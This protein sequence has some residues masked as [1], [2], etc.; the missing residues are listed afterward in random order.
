MKKAIKWSILIIGALFGAVAW[1][2]NEKRTIIN[3]FI[4]FKRLCT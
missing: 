3:P 4:N 2:S 1:N